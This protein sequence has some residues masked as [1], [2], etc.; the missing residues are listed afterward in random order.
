MF[1][2]VN[3]FNLIY[4]GNSLFTKTYYLY[5]LEKFR[6][7]NRTSNVEP[8]RF[9]IPSIQPSNFRNRSRAKLQVAR[10]H[11]RIFFLPATSPSSSYRPKARARTFSQGSTL[12]AEFSY[13]TVP[14]SDKNTITTGYCSVR[15]ATAIIIDFNY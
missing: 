7:Q 4:T 8:P 9:S 12:R 13:V 11:T 2:R 1:G 3:E 15:A 14:G 5:F 10:T 6:Q